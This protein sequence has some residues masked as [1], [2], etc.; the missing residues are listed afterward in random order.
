MAPH[1]VLSAL[2]HFED[3]VARAR[4]GLRAGGSL[5]ESIGEEC[6]LGAAREVRESLA[7]DRAERTRN[8]GQR[9]AERAADQVE[10]EVAR[11][12]AVLRRLAAV[13]RDDV[14]ELRALVSRS[15]LRHEPERHRIKDEVGDVLQRSDRLT[16]QQ[17]AGRETRTSQ[18]TEQALKNAR[19]SVV[20]GLLEFRVEA[21]RHQVCCLALLAIFTTRRAPR[22][23]L[24]IPR[25]M[26]TSQSMA[27]SG[28]QP[29]NGT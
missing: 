27:T 25:T 29:I 3:F 24:M 16:L 21:V 19:I 26:V 17:R 6:P 20:E 22:M 5:T 2:E 9:I 12:A 23:R 10:G 14:R 4:E 8:Q 7:E 1:L 15:E 11:E 28:S 18:P 13:V